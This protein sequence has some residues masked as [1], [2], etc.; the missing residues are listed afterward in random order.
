[1]YNTRDYECLFK[2]TAG[3]I[4]FVAA[5]CSRMY[6]SKSRIKGLQKVSMHDSP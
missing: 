1:M 5:P 4:C 2:D 3:M 6:G